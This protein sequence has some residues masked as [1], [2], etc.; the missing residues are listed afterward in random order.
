[1]AWR[2]HY[3]LAMDIWA[4]DFPVVTENPADD[5][6]HS[7]YAKG[8][9]WIVQKIGYE[10]DDCIIWPFSCC[11][12]GYGHFQYQK[13]RTLAHRFMCE[14]KNGP[15]PD[16]YLAAHSC[17]NRRCVNPNH[18]SWKDHS[19]NQ[20][21]RTTHG[22]RAMRRNKLTPNQ[23]RQIRG[24]KGIETSVQT[25]AKYGVTESNIRLIQ[26]GKTWQALI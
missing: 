20:L 21:D 9:H 11:T 14:Q 24:L 23:I 8:Y 5:P 16:G 22:N 26:D 4:V 12:P 2:I 3:R 13:K 18:L 15:A 10:G 25:A 6:S 7:S 1:M 17:G 19:G